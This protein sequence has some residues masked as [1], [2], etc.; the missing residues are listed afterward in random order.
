MDADAYQQY[1]REAR[2]PAAQGAAGKRGVLMPRRI[3]HDDR[4]EFTVITIWDGPESIIDSA[5]P[6]PALD[7]FEISARARRA[8]EPARTVAVKESKHP[9]KAAAGCSLPAASGCELRRPS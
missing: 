6:D 1:I 3:C 9:A 4:T 8:R 5:G 7:A 2:Y